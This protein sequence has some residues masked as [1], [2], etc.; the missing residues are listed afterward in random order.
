[1]NHFVQLLSGGDLNSM[2]RSNEAVSEVRNGDDFEELFKCMSYPDKVVRIRAGDAIEKITFKYP[3]YLL[4][5]KAGLMDLCC[6]ALD[7]ELKWNLALLVS[8]LHLTDNEKEVV[9]QRLSG[10]ALDDKENELTRSNSIQSLH[11]IAEGDNFYQKDF[12]SI[13]DQIKKENISFLNTQINTL[14][15]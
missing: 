6:R 4:E 11:E 15:T 2:G 3:T 10:W 14:L 1:M 9:W 5:H 12:E 8:R 7:K 13:A